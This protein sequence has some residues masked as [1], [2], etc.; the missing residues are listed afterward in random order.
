MPCDWL[1][2][3]TSVLR[4]IEQ[5]HLSPQHYELIGKQHVLDRTRVL[6]SEQCKKAN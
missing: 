2:Y 1:A 4:D 5:P 6:V 3:A